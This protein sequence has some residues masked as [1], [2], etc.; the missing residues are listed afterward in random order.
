LSIHYTPVP[1]TLHVLLRLYQ[2]PHSSVTFSPDWITY[3]F[4]D[5]VIDSFIS[6]IKALEFDV[7][8][9]DDLVLVLQENEQ[10]D[11]LR[12]VRG[13]SQ[14]ATQLQRLLH[15]KNDVIRRLGNRRRTGRFVKPEIVLYLGDVKDHSN[16]SNS[17]TISS[18]E[19][20][21]FFVSVFYFSSPS[22]CPNALN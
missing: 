3:A 21:I 1:H 7:D 18:T 22:T 4:L 15:F 11:M 14:N 13:A 17:L 12:R 5:D 8:C 16:L 6:V 9:I 19:K 20:K 10:Q 2:A